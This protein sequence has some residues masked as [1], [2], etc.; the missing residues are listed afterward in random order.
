MNSHFPLLALSSDLLVHV[1]AMAGNPAESLLVNKEIADLSIRVH[2]A[3]YDF[4]CENQNSL[5]RKRLPE[6]PEQVGQCLAPSCV[7]CCSATPKH[8]FAIQ[9]LFSIAARTSTPSGATIQASVQI[10]GTQVDAV[11]FAKMHCLRAAKDASVQYLGRCKSYFSDNIWQ[12]LLNGK[13]LTSH[14]YHE[15]DHLEGLLQEK[16]DRILGN[17]FQP[18]FLLGPDRVP[19]FDFRAQPLQFRQWLQVEGNRQS[20]LALEPQLNLGELQALRMPQEVASIPF[21]RQTFIFFLSTAIAQLDVLAID[22]LCRDPRLGLV[23]LNTLWQLLQDAAHRGNPDNCFSSLVRGAKVNRF[24]AQ[25]MANLMGVVVLH[26]NMRSALYFQPFLEALKRDEINGESLRL[27]LLSNAFINQLSRL[28]KA[29]IEELDNPDL[30]DPFLK[31]GI[32]NQ[33]PTPVFCQAM[34]HAF[35]TNKPM[36]QHKLSE[37]IFCMSEEMLRCLLCKNRHVA[38]LQVMIDH[39]RTGILSD[40]SLKAIGSWMLQEISIYENQTERF[41]IFINS[42]AVLK[43]SEESVTE[44]FK[45]IESLKAWDAGIFLFKN[46]LLKK[47][48]NQDAMNRMLHRIWGVQNGNLALGLRRTSGMTP[49]HIK[50]VDMVEN[51]VSLCVIL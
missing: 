23:P 14:S 46:R 25:E 38:S 13:P 29:I 18:M 11:S 45:K 2:G 22:A 50:Y 10:K 31:E 44:I 16:L 4:L 21:S 49:Q 19:A 1:L 26:P 9:A 24:S 51:Q 28:L 30:L 35:T 43:L 32:V 7:V 33:I 5:V 27:L 12:E 17:F 36:F 6:L 20:L 15:L 42:D 47:K 3:T 37:G 48:I 41:R 34:E 39:P 40:D 8:K